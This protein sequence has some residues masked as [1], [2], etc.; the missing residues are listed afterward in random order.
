MTSARPFASARPWRLFDGPLSDCGRSTFGIAD[1]ENGVVVEAQDEGYW[2][3]AFIVELANAAHALESGS[4]NEAGDR[5]LPADHDY[6]PKGIPVPPASLNQE[7][8]PHSG[9]GELE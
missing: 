5:A 9:E 8:R 4:G 1:A 2:N 6:Y 7:V 3:M